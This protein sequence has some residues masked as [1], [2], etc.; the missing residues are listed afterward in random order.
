MNVKNNNGGKWNVIGK[1]LINAGGIALA[2]VTL[3]MFFN[4]VT[5][6]AN[7]QIEV[8][9]EISEKMEQSNRIGEAQARAMESQASVMQ[10]QATAMEGLKNAI[11]FRLSY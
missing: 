1:V 8:M 3:Y 10:S 11:L 7:H 5:N 2:L 4:Y 9:T 6:H